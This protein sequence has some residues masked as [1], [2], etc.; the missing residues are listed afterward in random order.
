VVFTPALGRPF[1]TW[2]CLTAKPS[3]ETLGSDLLIPR[4]GARATWN[5][6]DTIP[7]IDPLIINE[8]WRVNLMG[9]PR[10]WS[11]DFPRDQEVWGYARMS[12]RDKDRRPGQGDFRKALGL[13]RLW[14][15]IGL[16]LLLGGV[17]MAAGADNYVPFRPDLPAGTKCLI[18]PGLLHPTQSAVGMREVE[19][20]IAKMKRWPAQRRERFLLEKTAPILI[21]PGNEVYLLDHHHLARMLLESRIKPLMYAE[22]KGN[23]AALSEH[24]FWALMKERQWVYLFDEAGRPLSDP[25]Q[26][27]R[28]IMDMRDDPYRSLSWLAREQGGYQDVGTPFLEFHWANFFRSR[29][30]IGPGR[31]GYDRA[32]SAAMRLCHSAEAKGLPGYMRPQAV[33]PPG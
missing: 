24:D 10:K 2:G 23:Y 9:G 16:G 7:F 32:L 30:T 15:V 19:L 28:R 17:A 18:D 20:R 5:Y 22:I 3:V 31:R 13:A 6:P 8:L 21:G 25:S 33:P 11:I 4:L 12:L 26:L 14:L 29:I 27:P 1:G